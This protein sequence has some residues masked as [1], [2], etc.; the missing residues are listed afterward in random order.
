MVHDVAKV[1]SRKIRVI[2]R[3]IGPNDL[4]GREMCSEIYEHAIDA[5]VVNDLGFIFWRAPKLVT[6]SIRRFPERC[7]HKEVVSPRYKALVGGDKAQDFH[8]LFHGA[9]SGC[10]PSRC[11][12]QAL[13]RGFEFR[14]AGPG[15]HTGGSNRTRAANPLPFVGDIRL[16]N[17]AT[18]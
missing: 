15:L 2:Q 9:K 3:G 4:C 10:A 8:Q 5:G 17:A 16:V 13:G 1:E 14:I 12:G 6:L 7:P 18:E 11:R